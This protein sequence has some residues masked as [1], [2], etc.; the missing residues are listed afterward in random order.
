MRLHRTFALLAACSSILWCAACS[1][2]QQA[3]RTA[4]PDGI[5]DKFVAE[6][7]DVDSFVARWE[8]ES[9]EVYLAQDEILR[10]VDLQPGEMV[11]DV[12]TGTGLYVEPFAA[13]VGRDGV[14]HALDI[15]PAFVA[16]VRRRAVDAGLTQVRPGLSSP[17]SINLP[18]GCVDA[19]FVWDVYH[20]FE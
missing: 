16:H 17:R 7:V 18:A 5:N 3:E 10:V 8:L 20:D 13:A 15:S 1:V 6:D 12:G 9:R 4:V 2:P 14:V 19:A 11:A